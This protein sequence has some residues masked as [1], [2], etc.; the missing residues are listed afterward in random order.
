MTPAPVIG[1]SWSCGPPPFQS[2]APISPISLYRHGYRDPPELGRLEQPAILP[3]RLITLLHITQIAH[4]YTY[5][6]YNK[7]TL[8]G[9]N[10]N[11]TFIV[12]ISAALQLH[13]TLHIL[14]IQ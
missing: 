7:T 14:H 3:H 8:P 6:T 4:Y 12:T 1:P 10:N 2:E 11:D 5:Y 13:H 9:C